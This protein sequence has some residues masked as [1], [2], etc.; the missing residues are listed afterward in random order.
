MK[1][2][3]SLWL[4]GGNFVVS[5]NITS[6]DVNLATTKGGVNSPTSLVNV[7]NSFVNRTEYNVSKA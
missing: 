6:A 4:E 2:V 7:T 3:K 5:P 1:V